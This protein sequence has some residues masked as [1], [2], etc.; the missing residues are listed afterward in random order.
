MI[1]NI[2]YNKQSPSM[3]SYLMVL[4]KAY[5]YNRLIHLHLLMYK[6]NNEERDFKNG[7]DNTDKRGR[8]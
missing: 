7:D 4:L 1:T 2:N 3:T 6:A 5:N 8:E